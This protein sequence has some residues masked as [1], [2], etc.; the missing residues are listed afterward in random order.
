M[1]VTTL[2][3]LDWSAVV[4][5]V[6]ARAHPEPL[7]ALRAAETDTHLLPAALKAL[8]RLPALRKRRVLSCY[9]ELARPRLATGRRNRVP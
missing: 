6:W 1:I 4:A 9:N 3:V 5:L 2:C 7:T 8:E